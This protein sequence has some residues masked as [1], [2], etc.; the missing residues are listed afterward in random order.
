M[1]K[2]L[3]AST[4]V[5]ALA[6]FSAPASAQSPF[7]LAKPMEVEIG[8]YVRI[9]H[10]Y[11]DLDESSPGAG[12]QTGREFQE[13]FEFNIDA[14]AE[15]TNGFEFGIDVDME[16]QNEQGVGKAFQVDEAEVIIRGGFGT[17][18]LGIEDALSDDLLINSP[19]GAG[20]GLLDGD[21][22]DFIANGANASEEINVA[23]SG[24]NSRVSYVTPRFE[25]LLAG[26]EY[27]P[28][29]DNGN[30]VVQSDAALTDA[31]GPRDTITGGVNYMN[32]FDGIGVGASV[33]FANTT[34]D[35]PAFDP[36]DNSARV[37]QWG[38]GMSVSYAGV[39]FS[40]AYV[41]H[42]GAGNDGGDDL[43]RNYNFGVLYETGP[44][45]VGLAYANTKDT[46][47]DVRR[48][49]AAAASYAV[50]EGLDVFG[51]VDYFIVDSGFN[52]GGNGN[53]NNNDLEG[54]AGIMGVQVSY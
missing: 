24:E 4:A 23:T 48:N 14:F 54:I 26:I 11:W 41:D 44:I 29:D 18:S 33:V 15:T 50:A 49:V 45:A 43:E 17:V 1:K 2:I 40:G 30:N 27:A 46:G 8:G 13:D 3:L 28:E 22:G 39:T 10:G 52:A 6:A 34:F 36:T 31:S 51:Q 9:E 37:W 47:S 20:H 32:T 42:G 16:M 19:T 25:G 21:L 35:Q 7:E 12:N 53:A 38:V 5:A